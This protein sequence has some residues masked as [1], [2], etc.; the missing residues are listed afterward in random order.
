MVILF[1][2]HPFEIW[3]LKSFS[4]IKKI[5]RKSP[6]ITILEWCPHDFNKKTE[7]KSV[8]KESD[9]TDG[10]N[11]ENINTEKENIICIDDSGLMYSFCVET[12]HIKDGAIV[13]PEDGELMN[14]SS[15]DLK[16]DFIVCGDLDGN[17]SRWNLRTRFL[18]SICY[19]R[20]LEIKKVKFAPGKENMLL[21][22]QYNE[23]IQIYDINN[24]DLFSEFKL[25]SKI[26]DSNWCS[27]DRL[28][29]QFSDFSLKI[30]D[31]NFNI[32]FDYGQLMAPNLFN[33]EQK[34][35][36]LFKLKTLIF[37]R[38]NQN[39]IN[40]LSQDLTSPELV[41][42]LGQNFQNTYKNSIDRFAYVSLLI[43]LNGFETKFWTLFSYLTETDK[44]SNKRKFRPV[45]GHNSL[46][47]NSSEFCAKE[48]DMLNLYRDKIEDQQN[49]SVLRDF[50]LSNQLDSAFN[51]LME[52]DPISESYTNNLVKACL[53]ASVKN[54][55]EN[56][57]AKTSIKLVATSLIANGKIYDGV[58]L[59]CLI[60][61]I[62]DACRYLQ[63]NN[64][65]E[66]A[67]WLAKMRLSENEQQEIIKR[68]SE[69]LI[70]N[71]IN[72]K[73]SAIF[74]LLSC[75]SYWKVLDL[76]TD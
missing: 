44:I 2:E 52:S 21:L 47:V 22:V 35:T 48:I 76:L 28:F 68:W 30:F 26:L 43:N 45:L 69:Y 42:I 13:L 46:M 74:L 51:F 70:S 67:A 65:W 12:N 50:I 40:E 15:I 19:K 16:K 71:T 8:A 14:V 11:S 9:A 20:G 24:L 5:S 29:I 3:D 27:S 57:Q 10:Q 36:N 39:K 61:L 31:V 18:K 25:K 73:E 49:N 66:K 72:R 33:L 4:L 58:E 62:F 60:G 32:N 6:I 41:K 59:L 54:S 55:D 63:D 53:I 38:L 17:L 64:E 37:D 23:L 7:V 34:E 56:S 1:K 75:N